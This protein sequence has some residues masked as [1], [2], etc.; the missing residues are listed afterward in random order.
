[1]MI[2]GRSE[3][4]RSA[5][6]GWWET[7]ICAF[8]FCFPGAFELRF[9]YLDLSEGRTAASRKVDLLG[10][11]EQTSLDDC[12]LRFVLGFA[13]PVCRS[14]CTRRRPVRSRCA[15]SC[16]GSTGRFAV[17]GGAA[18]GGRLELSLVRLERLLGSLRPVRRSRTSLSSHGRWLHGAPC[19]ERHLCRL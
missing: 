5:W 2:S 19:Y 9:P 3:V 15:R 11:V 12:L 4:E 1:M 14:A 6:R 8:L 7:H 16:P 10:R 13:F 18:S 17:R